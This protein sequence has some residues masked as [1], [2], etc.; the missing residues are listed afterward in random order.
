M[1]ADDVRGAAGRPDRRAQKRAAE[2]VSEIESDIMARGWPV[3]EVIGTV[4]DLIDRY[5]VS[6]AVIRE[7]IGLLEHK[8]IVKMRHGP[9]GGVEVR[10]PVADAVIGAISTYLEFSGVTNRE[11]AELRHLLVGL[12]ARLATERIDEAGVA[13]L[14]RVLD[15]EQKGMQEGASAVARQLD[16]YVCVA[17]LSGNPAL[18]L[19]WSVLMQRLVRPMIAHDPGPEEIASMHVAH[20]QVV[21]A[22]VS[23]DASRAESVMREHLAERY[24]GVV[25]PIEIEGQHEQ[26]YFRDD[27]L[28]AFGFSFVL[29]NAS[30]REKLPARVARE[31]KD[32]ILEGSLAAGEVIG[33]EGDLLE[34]FGVSRSV[35]R[36]AV[37]IVEFYGLAEMRRGPRGGLTVSTPHAETMEEAVISYLEF[38]GIELHHLLEVRVAIELMN[39]EWTIERTRDG[40]DELSDIVERERVGAVPS[41]QFALHELLS[42]LSGNRASALLTNVLSRMIDRQVDMQTL[43][44][45]SS[46]DE[47]AAINARGHA[48]HVAIVEAVLAGD[49]AL[50]RHRML[51]HLEFISTAFDRLARVQSSSD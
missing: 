40:L 28:D 3:G 38:M 26:P 16:F 4:S 32:L 30:P 50:A 8:M 31:I 27:E 1:S 51:R 22:V 46:P 6:R 17:E 47:G 13:R 25:A 45:N 29:A 24:E 42:R 14:R 7:A 20:D 9:G 41:R 33:M 5:G 48:E 15:D 2:V 34:R 44:P 12:A 23:G 49:V 43:P 21:R 39:V 10:A 35:F 36:E 18:P 11:L 37:R 19:F